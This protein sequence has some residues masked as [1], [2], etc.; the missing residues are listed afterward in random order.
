MHTRDGGLVKFVAKTFSDE[1]VISAIKANSQVVR[2]IIGIVPMLGDVAE[3]TRD[4][5]AVKKIAE[6]YLNRVT[7]RAYLQS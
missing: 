5:E 7:T 6:T 1:S 2:N 4:G 3:Y